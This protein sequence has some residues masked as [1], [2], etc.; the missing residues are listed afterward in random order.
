MKDVFVIEGLRTPL[1]SF[2]G[3]LSEIPTVRLGALAIRET[4]K[5]ANISAGEVED[6]L[7]GCV[8]SG[9]LGQAP[10][11]QASIY[12]GLPEKV[13]CVTVSKVC[14]SGLKS[15][16]LGT[17]SIRGG[18]SGLAVCGGMENM[19]L[20]PYVMHKAR[21][22]LRMGNA[23]VVDMMVNDGLW[24]PYNNYHMG[25]AAELCASELNIS[26]EEQ[27]AY[28]IRSYERAIKAIK[29][30]E[31]KREIIPVEIKDKKGQITVVD[32]DEEPFKAKLDR[33][34]T[35]RPAFKKDGTVTAANA[36]SINDGAG[37]V[38]LAD[39]DT[40]KRLGLKPRFRVVGY[41]EHS[42]Q[43]EWFTT[44]PAQAIKNLWAKIG[45]KESDVDLY[46]INE[47]FA[48]VSLAN[49]RLAGIAEE[50]VNIRGGA[51]A[52]GHPIGASGTRVL[53]TL[54]H[55]LED[56]NLKRGI[57]SLCNGGGEGTALAIE[58]V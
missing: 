5:K 49:N 6:V 11:R 52:L 19:S 46:E 21:T 53:V 31:F 57:C 54:M 50:K 15:V 4:L 33:I 10:A 29:A 43:P 1:G 25:M 26:R 9:G 8:L 41:A 38:V 56:H 34:T 23:E 27:D 32:T 2:Q 44:A 14:G 55:A 18:D 28:A 45:W 39:E 35:L 13:R 7:M 36:S 37:A 3:S 30:G 42:Q 51:V 20:A 58:K 12:G 47:A 24:D 48:V 17:L 40:V 16:M 22:G